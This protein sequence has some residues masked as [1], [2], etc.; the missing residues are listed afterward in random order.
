MRSINFT[1]LVKILKILY[2]FLHVY[3]KI[4]VNLR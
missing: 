4:I 2:I 1:K 3:A